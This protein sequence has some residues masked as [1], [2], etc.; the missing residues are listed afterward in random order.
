MT[1]LPFLPRKY[2]SQV[3][4]WSC[5]MIKKTKNDAEACSAGRPHNSFHLSA[6]AFCKHIIIIFYINFYLIP[7]FQYRLFYRIFSFIVH[8]ALILWKLPVMSRS[9]NSMLSGWSQGMLNLTQDYRCWPSDEL[10]PQQIEFAFPLSLDWIYN[11]TDSQI[12]ATQCWWNPY[13]LFSH[14]GR[15]HDPGKCQLYSVGPANKVR[16]LQHLTWVYVTRFVAV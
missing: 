5:F 2:S 3:G 15:I 10:N 1:D 6:P 11:T 16:M 4:T 12:T 8:I 7:I 13:H 9:L 14:V